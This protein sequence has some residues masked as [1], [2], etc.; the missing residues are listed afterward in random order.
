MI[1][2]NRVLLGSRTTFMFKRKL[3]PQGQAS[4]SRENLLVLSMKTSFVRKGLIRETAF[5]LNGPSVFLTSPFRNEDVRIRLDKST[6]RKTALFQQL[7]LD[8][9]PQNGKYHAVQSGAKIP[10]PACEDTASLLPSYSRQ[11][12]TQIMSTLQCSVSVFSL[13]AC[14][15]TRPS[16][17]YRMGGGG[18]EFFPKSFI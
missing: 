17:P 2:K 3:T 6:T 16:L 15:T 14:Q 10:G 9:L 7:D 5:P 1:L 12:E 11:W 13:S 4:T 18:G 8:L